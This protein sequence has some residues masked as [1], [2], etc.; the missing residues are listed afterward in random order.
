MNIVEITCIDNNKTKMIYAFFLD[1][2][3]EANGLN[4]FTGCS[5]SDSISSISF[6][7]YN[8]PEARPNVIKPTI[9]RERLSRLSKDNEKINGKKTTRFL[10]HCLILTSLR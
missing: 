8:A 5:L 2:F 1:I 10:Y 4:F 6:L 3:P 7:I 9:V